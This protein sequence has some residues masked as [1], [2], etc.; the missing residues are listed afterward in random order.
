MN[1]LY[2]TT[3]TRFTGGRHTSIL[4][5]NGLEDIRLTDVPKMLGSERKNTW[6]QER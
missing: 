1:Y 4:P 6:M 2:R 5:R 3:E